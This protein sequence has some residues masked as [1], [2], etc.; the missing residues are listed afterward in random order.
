MTTPLKTRPGAPV[1]VENRAVYDRCLSGADLRVL[2]LVSDRTG[3]DA[4]AATDVTNRQIG[5][6]LGLHTGTVTRAVANLVAGGYLESFQLGS[7]RGPV[8]WLKLKPTA[9]GGAS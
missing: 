3:G 4:S 5:D 9:E 6:E 7:A 1:A 8:R 2:L